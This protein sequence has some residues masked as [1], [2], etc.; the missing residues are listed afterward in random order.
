SG[1]PL[2][3]PGAGLFISIAL[4]VLFDFLGSLAS[5][6][7]NEPLLTALFRYTGFSIA[8]ARG[9]ARKTA[10]FDSVVQLTN[11]SRALLLCNWSMLCCGPSDS[12]DKGALIKRGAAAPPGVAATIGGRGAGTILSFRKKLLR[13]F[14]TYKL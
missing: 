2:S 6:A 12:R 14:K 4:A 8:R 7:A 9:T 10:L 5:T 1:S 3:C 13:T 11:S